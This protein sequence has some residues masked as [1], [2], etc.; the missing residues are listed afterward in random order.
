M[1]GCQKCTTMG[2]YWKMSY[3][4]V[5]IAR[6]YIWVEKR[7]LKICANG[8]LIS[9]LWCWECHGTGRDG[10]EKSRTLQQAPKMFH[11]LTLFFKLCAWEIFYC[12]KIK[13]T[14]SSLWA[15][16]WTGLSKTSLMLVLTNT[17]LPIL[18]STLNNFSSILFSGLVI[19]FQSFQ[20]G[21]PILDKIWKTFIFD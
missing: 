4:L 16:G 7:M 5:V 3:C 20:W 8:K 2:L 12:F 21:R 13:P 15:S 9:G 10:R 17:S 14:S 11:F 6:E 19:S 1:D 18:T